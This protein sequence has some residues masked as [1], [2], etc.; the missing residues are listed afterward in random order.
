MID[1]ILY[2]IFLL[3]ILCLEVKPIESLDDTS[4]EPIEEV[5]GICR[6]RNFTN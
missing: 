2:I 5:I 1:N 3:T 4:G 6:D